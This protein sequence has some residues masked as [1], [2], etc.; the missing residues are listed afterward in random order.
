MVIGI[1]SAMEEELAILLE[2]M[3]VTEKKIKAN[4][5]FHKGRLWDKDV[6]AVVSG[7]GKVNAAIC[8]QILISEYNVDH[9]INVGVAGGIGMD[10]YP[11]DV[12][13]AENLVQYDMDTTAFG[14]KHGQIPRLDTFDFLCNKDLVNVCKEACSEIEGFNTF[15][16]RIVSGDQFVASIEK[17]KWLEQEF[18]AKAVEME[19]AS[20]AHVCYLNDIPFVVIR[21]IS[22]NAN[23][24]A[25]MDYEKFTPIG[26]KNST[27]ILKGM[28][29]KM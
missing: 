26:V 18:E 13:I 6:V 20:I 3:E 4:M 28:I 14:D 10:I 12:V 5:T 11:G 24:G 1:I 19:G 17:I 9:V 2:D 22:D 29:H 7:I 16:G 8:T 21:S 15:S 25:H 27:T 23:N